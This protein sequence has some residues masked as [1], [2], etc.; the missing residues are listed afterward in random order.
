MSIPC[1]PIQRSIKP[2]KNERKKIMNTEILSQFLPGVYARVGGSIVAH[3]THIGLRVLALRRARD[4]GL[5]Y[6]E[7]GEE[8]YP[9][10]IGH[11]LS[12]GLVSKMV[13]WQ[14]I[15]LGG[16]ATFACPG[17]VVA[18]GIAADISI[19]DDPADNRSPRFVGRPNHRAEWQSLA[20]DVAGEMLSVTISLDSTGSDVTIQMDA[21]HTAAY[22]WLWAGRLPADTARAWLDGLISV[23]LDA[24]PAV[25]E[26][27]AAHESLRSA[28]AAIQAGRKAKADYQA[29]AKTLRDDG[30]IGAEIGLV[31]HG[32]GIGDPRC[33][34]AILTPEPSDHV[35]SV[36]YADVSYDE[37]EDR[38]DALAMARRI[39]GDL[40]R[41]VVIIIRGMQGN[42]CRY[43]GV[44]YLAASKDD[45]WQTPGIHVGC[46]RFG[47][48]RDY[49]DTTEI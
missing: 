46:T 18:A 20:A 10:C 35:L 14:Q 19:M 12:H 33:E 40:S 25:T 27:D 28:E 37:C 15:G 26:S 8:V 34:Y 6:R 29:R 3:D 9:A 43:D 31:L 41:N 13:L 23:W 22:P 48:R 11:M 38:T 21:A 39:G 24:Q 47:I 30:T 4:L 17:A 2:A 45:Y 49:G 32:Y 16:N 1:T 42:G 5:S 36:D 7:A 44:I